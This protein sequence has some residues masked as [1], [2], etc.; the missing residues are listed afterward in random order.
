MKDHKR[1]KQ[2]FSYQHNQDVILYILHYS[3]TQLT[4]PQVLSAQIFVEKNVIGCSFVLTWLGSE[5]KEGDPC[6]H[7]YQDILQNL[8][9]FNLFSL[10]G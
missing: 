9:M 4:S 6:S 5:A 10:A 3:L 2:P 1:V 7:T 8:T